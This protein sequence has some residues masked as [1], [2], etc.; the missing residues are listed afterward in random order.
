MTRLRNTHAFSHADNGAFEAA[1]FRSFFE[2][3][4]LGDAEATQGKLGAHVIRAVPGAA[5]PGDRDIHALD[6][7][8]LYD[9]GNAEMSAQH[10]ADYE[11]RFANSFGA[12]ERGLID[13]VI[14]PHSTRKRVASA[15]ASLRGKRLK[16]PWKKHDYIPL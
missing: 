8:L 6:F 11:D 13:E 10:M 5:S 16:S 9:L 12:A 3:R 2:Y 1:G 4:Q 14:M 7:Q 15:F